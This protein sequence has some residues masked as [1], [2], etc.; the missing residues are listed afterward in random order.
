MRFFGS[1]CLVVAD[2]IALSDTPSD[3][4]LG[5][6]NVA[7]DVALYCRQQMIHL[8]GAWSR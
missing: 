5:L 4:V 7:V 8:V 3:L 1:L 6:I 2:P